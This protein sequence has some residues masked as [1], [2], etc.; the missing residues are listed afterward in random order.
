MSKKIK[1]W[2]DSGAN[3]HSKRELVIAIDKLG[4]DDEW[5]DEMTYQEQEEV[6]R[7]IAFERLDWG[8][9]EIED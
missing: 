7:E 4:I 6:M 3:I 1:V 2:I 9:V 8:F 5:W